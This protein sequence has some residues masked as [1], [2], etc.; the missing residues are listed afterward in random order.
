MVVLVNNQLERFSRALGYSFKNIKLLKKA[1]TH[2]SVGADNYERFEFV[3]DSI[4]S[5][6]IAHELFQRFPQES[7]G[8]LS[9]IRAFLVKGDML[10]ELARE[11]SLGDYLYLGQGELKSGGFRRDSILAD[12]L[13]AIFAA[14]YFDGG[15]ESAREVIL[16]LYRSRLEHNELSQSVKDY[17]TQLQEYLQAR[18]KPLPEYQL[19]QTDGEG[20][21]QTFHVI[22]R[23]SSIQHETKGE[24]V[25]RRKAEQLAA[26]LFLHYLTQI[27]Q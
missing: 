6:V 19:V 3:G 15:M 2:C 5:F 4:L 12:S 26:Q 22:C 14:I 16:R 8:Q 24:G 27:Q 11:L 9:R 23:V 21:D 18:K 1:L 20:H 10:A 7:E 25:S 17:K 13:E